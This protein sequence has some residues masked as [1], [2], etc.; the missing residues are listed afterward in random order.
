MVGGEMTDGGGVSGGGGDGGG[1]DSGGGGDGGGGD[2]GGGVDGD[3]V[4]LVLGAFGG[5]VLKFFEDDG[6]YGGDGGDV[7][8]GG[9]G[10]E[11]GR[12]GGG[13]TTTGE[14]AQIRLVFPKSVSYPGSGVL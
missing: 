6:L 1:G 9:A 7:G 11:G 3:N 12:E 8:D 10:G 14:P 13:H 5:T 4:R 2:S